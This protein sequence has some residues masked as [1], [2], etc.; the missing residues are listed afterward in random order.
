MDGTLVGLIAF[1]ALILLLGLRV[2]IAFA[3]ARVATMATFVIFAFRTGTFT[4]DRAIR[5]TTSMVF[6]NTFDL[7]HTYNLSMI[8]LF[9]A[10]GH[11]AYRAEITTRKST[12]R[13]GSG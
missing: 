3:L 8:P 2:P 11:I 9:V 12:A 6:S 13:P 10:L 1:A 4:P 5:P 7:I